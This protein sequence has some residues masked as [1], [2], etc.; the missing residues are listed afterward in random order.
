MARRFGRNQ[1]RKLR[2]A[3]ASAN[4]SNI[5]L[6][7]NLELLREEVYSAKRILSQNSVAFEA[8][9]MEV[10]T[11]ELG[12]LI[13]LPSVSLPQTYEDFESFSTFKDIPLNVLAAKARK[14]FQQNALHVRVTLKDKV[15]GYALSDEALYSTPR[16]VLIQRMSE[17]IA[18]MLVNELKIVK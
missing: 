1:K 8:S 6:R 3:I 2:A 18:T 12:R 10:H 5:G 9:N 7:T 13:K 15:I 4:V 14:D 11:E 16:K 17:E